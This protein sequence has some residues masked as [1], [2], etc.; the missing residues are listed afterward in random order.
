MITDGLFLDAAAKFERDNPDIVRD[1]LL[2]RVAGNI[3]FQ[4]SKDNPTMSHENRL[5]LTA[6]AVR[7][8]LGKY[9]TKPSEGSNEETED[10]RETSVPRDITQR[11]PAVRT[12][13]ATDADGVVSEESPEEYAR[14]IARMAAGRGQQRPRVHKLSGGYSEE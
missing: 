2:F 1:P 14:I 8:W 11:R 13:W 3:D 5:A 7:E 10:T 9:R 12:Q 6:K 4:L